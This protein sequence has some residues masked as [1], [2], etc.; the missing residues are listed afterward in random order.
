MTSTTL[1]CTAIALA[2]TLAAAPGRA[3]ADDPPPA[4]PP[5]GYAQQPPPPQ[6]YPPPGY[7]PP[8]QPAPDG[9]PAGAPPGYAQPYSAPIYAPEEIDDVD[10]DRPAPPGYTRVARARKGL[11][12]GGSVTF[13][14][15]FLVTTFVAA[16]A[17][18]INK[19]DGS[20]ANVTPMY[21]PVIG[22]FLELG[23]TDNSVARFYLTMLGLGQAAGATMLIVG[24]TSP[25]MLL[26]RNDRLTLAPLLGD[27]ATGLAIR[28]RF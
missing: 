22:P 15:T 11:I 19:A 8:Y 3:S 5:P 26:V 16:V 7:P 28:G 13:G 14:S 21:L 6:G 4:P 9:Q 18:E 1:R 24:L 17:D 25:R 10:A 12:I 2:I 20:N 23:E 27:H